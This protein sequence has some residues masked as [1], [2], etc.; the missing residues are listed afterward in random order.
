[1]SCPICM[2]D[3]VNNV[4]CVTTECGHCFHASCLMTNVAHNGFECP[5]CR[6]KM[7]EDQKDNEHSRGRTLGLEEDDV[8]NIVS[9]DDDDNEDDVYN[10]VSDDD[11]DDNEEDNMLRGYRL[12]LNG[13]EETQPDPADI[14]AEDIFVEGQDQDLAE[15]T[16][17]EES[18]AVPS[19]ELVAKNLKDQGITYEKL[20]RLILYSDHAEYDFLNA[21]QFTDELFGKIRII[22]SNY[23]PEI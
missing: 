1:M 6:T 7:A 3:I 22:V 16:T 23:A 13:V 18:V 5:Y 19:L 20:L 4:N 11:D 12:F 9:D 15:I 17:E 8:Y 10:I 21:D 14:Y 2:D